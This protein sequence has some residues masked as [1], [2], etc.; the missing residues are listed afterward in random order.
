MFSWWRPT[1][2]ATRLGVREHMPASPV[3]PLEGAGRSGVR[4][5]ESCVLGVAR[6]AADGLRYIPADVCGEAEAVVQFRIQSNMKAQSA[7]TPGSGA[8][9]ALMTMSC[10]ADSG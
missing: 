9:H 8:W 3:L 10:F 2:G 6:M 1:G 4:R 5:P 7:R